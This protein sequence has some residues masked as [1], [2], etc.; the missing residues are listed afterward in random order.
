M[1]TG[2]DALDGSQRVGRLDR[3]ERSKRQPRDSQGSPRSQAGGTL[4][5]A[6]RESGTGGDRRMAAP[7]SE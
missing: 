5:G 4:P 1:E 6:A 2:S 3:F 7:A